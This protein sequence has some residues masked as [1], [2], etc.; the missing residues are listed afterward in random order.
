MLIRKCDRCRKE[1][2]NTFWTI[3]IFAE[4]DEKGQLNLEGASNNLITNISKTKEYCADCI[5]EI[6]AFIDKDINN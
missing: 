3:R 5:N 4:T 1:I 6:K 2:K